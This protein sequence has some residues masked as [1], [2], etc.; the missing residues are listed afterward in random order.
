[1]LPDFLK[2]NN[3]NQPLIGRSW[4]PGPIPEL[5]VGVRR[6]KDLY[7]FLDQLYGLERFW[8]RGESKEY[9]TP[10]GVITS[11]MPTI[12]RGVNEDDFELNIEPVNKNDMDIILSVMTKQELEIIENF[13]TNHPKDEYFEKLVDTTSNT[14]GWFSY[15]QHYGEKT[16]LLDVSGDPLV[17][18]Y[19]ACNSNDGE[20]GWIFV[21]TNAIKVKPSANYETMFDCSIRDQ[22]ALAFHQEGRL[23]DFN[24]SRGLGGVIAQPWL[25]EIN[26]PNKRIIKQKGAFIWSPTPFQPLTQGTIVI[27]VDGNSKEHIRNELRAFGITSKDLELE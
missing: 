4:V 23:D 2:S 21:Y 16:R 1:M 8:L 18:L 20:D 11:G 17:A 19:F 5:N 9:R 3:H 13:K 22:Q 25:F 24:P 10:D 26:E 7:I 6:V 27:K 12:T 15:A 14:P